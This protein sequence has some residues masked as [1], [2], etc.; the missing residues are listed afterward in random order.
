MGKIVSGLKYMGLLNYLSSLLHKK[1]AIDTTIPLF[2]SSHGS[3]EIIP[4]I[5]SLVWLL[6]IGLLCPSEYEL[7]IL[8]SVSVGTGIFFF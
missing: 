5:V 4:L 6:L 7:I 2:S 8:I 3:A 1:S